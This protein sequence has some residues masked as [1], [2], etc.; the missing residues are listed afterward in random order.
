MQ[1]QGGWPTFV[2]FVPLKW[3]RGNRSSFWV[4]SRSQ[5]QFDTWVCTGNKSEWG[6]LLSLTTT[7]LPCVLPG[8]LFPSRS[9]CKFRYLSP[10]TW[11]LLKS[12]KWSSAFPFL[13]THP[14]HHPWRVLSQ[15]PGNHDSTQHP[16]ADAST[17][18]VFNLRFSLMQQSFPCLL[19]SALYTCQGWHSA[20]SCPRLVYCHLCLCWMS[21]LGTASY[22][23][24]S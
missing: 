11:V 17:F 16:I 18:K 22:F 3:T 14:F 6:S 15:A 19:P 2:T 23:L 13:I 5:N 1:Q 8:R 12:P 10:A 4:W 21:L 20:K 7:V 24:S 9:P